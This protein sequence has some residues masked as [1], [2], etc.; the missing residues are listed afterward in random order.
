MLYSNSGLRGVDWNLKVRVA[1]ILLHSKRDFEIWSK[2]EFCFNQFCLWVGRINI[3]YCFSTNIKNILQL[4]SNLFFLILVLL[5]LILPCKFEG[6]T[7]EC[8][9]PNL[10]IWKTDSQRNHAWRFSVLTTKRVFNVNMVNRPLQLSVGEPQK[11]KIRQYQQTF[12]IS[13]VQLL[14]FWHTKIEIIFIGKE[15]IYSSFSYLVL[16]SFNWMT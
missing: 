4:N 11:N 5:L 12:K 10:N 2:R 6:T 16:D 3:C 7:K 15:S 13:K 14:S 1:R 9:F 8:D